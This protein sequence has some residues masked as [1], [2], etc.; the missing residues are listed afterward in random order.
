MTE[1]RIDP[2]RFIPRA[3]GTLTII[4]FAT[5]AVLGIYVL[6]SRHTRDR[7]FEGLESGDLSAVIKGFKGP[8]SHFDKYG[9]TPLTRAAY[10]RNREAIR[11]LLSVGYDPNQFDKLLDSPPILYA[12][13]DESIVRILLQGGANP[14]LKGGAAVFAMAASRCPKCLTEVLQAGGDCNTKSPGTGRTPLM[15]AAFE[16]R[17]YNIEILYNWGADLN[18]LD[19]RKR[20]AVDYAMDRGHIDAAMFL[21]ELSLPR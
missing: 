14:S 3:I 7:A 5:F 10:Y 18:A 17:T 9:F 20:A 4:G 21:I 2:R 13:G 19:N 8:P 1:R 15:A 12:A 6:I 16:G 11:Y